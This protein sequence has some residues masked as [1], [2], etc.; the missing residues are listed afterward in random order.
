MKKV[1]SK[2]F[3]RFLTS[4]SIF[5]TFGYRLFA[6]MLAFQGTKKTAKKLLKKSYYNSLSVLI[7]KSTE[8][9]RL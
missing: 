5:V 3:E 1:L 9:D 6:S 7:V 4:L 8:A 2:L